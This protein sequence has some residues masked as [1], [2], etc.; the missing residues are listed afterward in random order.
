MVYSGF[1]TQ[2]V[3]QLIRNGASITQTNT[4]V[5]DALA[6]LV[7]VTDNDNNTI[8]YKYY[9]ESNNAVKEVR[10]P[11]YDAISQMGLI[12]TVTDIRNNKILMIDPDMGDWNYT[13]NGFGELVLQTDARGTTTD[14]QYDL[15]GRVVDKTIITYVPDPVTGLPTTQVETTRADQWLYDTLYPGQLTSITGNTGEAYQYDSLGRAVA[16]TTTV[17]G[18]SES[19]SRTHDAWGRPDI[20]HYPENFSVKHHYLANGHLDKVT[21]L[22]QPS[23]VY[24]QATAANEEGTISN[25]T[26]GNG[27]LVTRTFKVGRLVSQGDANGITRDRNY[28]YDSID[29]LIKREVEAPASVVGGGWMQ[30]SFTYDN[31]NRLQSAHLVAGLLDTTENYSYDELGNITSKQNISS[32]NYHADIKKR[33]TSVSGTGIN[34]SFTYDRNGSMLTSGNMQFTWSG[35]NK[36]LAINDANDVNHYELY[37]YD[38]NGDRVWNRSAS[39]SGDTTRFYLQHAANLGM[40]YEQEAPSNNLTQK[41]HK[42]YIYVGASMVAMEKTGVSTATEYYMKDHLGSI[43]AVVDQNLNVISERSFDS[44]GQNRNIDW[45]AVYGYVPPSA[46]FTAAT[47]RGYTGHEHIASFGLINMN[48]RIYDPVIGRFISA[49][50]FVQFADNLQSY[51]RY[52]YVLNN[53]LNA[54]DPSGYLSSS[55]FKALIPI[56]M[57]IFVPYALGLSKLSAAVV[58]GFVGGFSSAA[59]NGGSF[60]DAFAGGIMGAISGAVFYGVGSELRTYSIEKTLAHGL[61]GGLMSELRGGDFGTGFISAGF[62][63][64]ALGGVDIQNDFLDGMAAAVVGGTAAVIGGGKFANGA[65]T[66]A[67][68]R[69]FNKQLHPKKNLKETQQQAMLREN[70]DTYGYY[71]ARSD[72]GDHYATVA[73][74]IVMT[75]GFLP[76]LV[77]TGGLANFGLAGTEFINGVSYDE[78]NVNIKLMDAHADYVRA[79]NI[80]VYG[81][82]SDREIAQYHHD[83][84]RSMGLP[85]STF[86]GTPITGG[87][88]DIPISRWIMK[89]VGGADWCSGCDPKSSI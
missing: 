50:P 58:G 53:P 51:N 25:Y 9:Y 36:V 37:Q 59:I 70:G 6:R 72:A 30:E 40:H 34:K 55:L 17:N 78:Y 35:K 87:L 77:T 21:N 45:A 38:A 14:I 64:A 32:Y 74:D 66:A 82:L 61:A 4:E 33:L 62:S 88:N 20:L 7:S 24:W 22:N 26:L 2:T 65:I 27:L 1:T 71:R 63:E 76:H 80:G 31:L 47:D 13:Y 52:A 39:S 10:D 18:F 54:T 60:R 42:Y 5:K 84:F 8:N 15:L 29:N 43:T 67:F 73:M 16:K 23:K 89:K 81:L 49:D 48:G 75:N 69:M 83:V 68:G 11:T 56:G 41:T 44:F 3:Q 85:S 46:L 57:A 28:Q 12:K 79:D 86:G 19:V